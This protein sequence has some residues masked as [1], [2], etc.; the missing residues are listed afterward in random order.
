MFH[1]YKRSMDEAA[2]LWAVLTVLLRGEVY[3]AQRYALTQFAKVISAKDAA[4]LAAA[5]PQSDVRARP[6]GCGWAVSAGGHS[7]LPAEAAARRNPLPSDYPSARGEG[8]SRMASRR[9]RFER[10]N[11][12]GPRE[13]PSPE[14]AR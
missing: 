2:G 4:E 11:N 12:A 8:L 7:R 14:T 9:F 1:F 3:E 13:P 5:V 10:P 6:I